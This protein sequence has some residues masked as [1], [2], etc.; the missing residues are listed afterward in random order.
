MWALE[1][2]DDEDKAVKILIE[3]AKNDPSTRVRRTAIQVLGGIDT[4]EAHDALLEILKDRSKKKDKD[5]L[6]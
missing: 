1:D 3:V 2:A 4:D 5:Y 6:L